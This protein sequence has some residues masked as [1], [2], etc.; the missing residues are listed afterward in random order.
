MRPTSTFFIIQLSNSRSR[1]LAYEG[2]AVWV[3]LQYLLAMGQKDRAIMYKRN[4]DA[5]PSVYGVGMKMF[6]DKYQIKEVTN[7]AD[8]KTPFK[9][10]P[11]I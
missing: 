9:K 2:M 4:R 6:I 3:E 7:L 11:P 5:D 8:K 1:N 10:F